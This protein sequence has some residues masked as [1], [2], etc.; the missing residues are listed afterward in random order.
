[1][2]KGGFSWRRLSGVSKL[3]S[4]ISRA[5]GIPLTK[6]G[7]QRK[8]GKLATGGGC[9]LLIATPFVLVCMLLAVIKLHH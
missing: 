4:Q 1:M 7:R 6:G 9:L 8:I 3:K 5:S 2:N